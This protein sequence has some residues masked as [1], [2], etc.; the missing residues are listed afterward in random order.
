[1]LYFGRGGEQDGA[2]GNVKRNFRHAAAI[3]L[4]GWY[5]MVPPNA[6]SDLPLSAWENQFQFKT[7]VECEDFR[8]QMVAMTAVLML[9]RSKTAGGQID[10]S[11]VPFFAEA[12]SKCV[13]SNDSRLKGD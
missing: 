9:N 4:T 3:A 2:G 10:Q 12:L 5:L 11:D 8:S 1:M 13:S 6:K 7:V